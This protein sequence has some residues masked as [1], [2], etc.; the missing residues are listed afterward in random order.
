M[1]VYCSALD[2]LV[3]PD[4][5]VRPTVRARVGPPPEKAPAVKLRD[6]STNT[7]SDLVYFGQPALVPG[8][9]QALVKLVPSD[10]PVVALDQ[11]GNRRLSHYE[12]PAFD[13][14]PEKASPP[15]CGPLEG[16]GVVPHDP[17]DIRGQLEPMHFT[18]PLDKPSKQ[19]CLVSEACETSSCAAT[20]LRGRRRTCKAPSGRM[21]SRGSGGTSSGPTCS[22]ST[23]FPIRAESGLKGARQST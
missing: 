2:R 11:A 1:G 15:R 6:A 4:R 19:W 5:R 3:L 16:P 22:Q 7:V 8:L 12:R 20:G 14:E 13:F 17:L 23:R 10:E 21:P 18:F 9:V